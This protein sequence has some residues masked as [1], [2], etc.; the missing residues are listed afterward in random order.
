MALPAIHYMSIYIK[1]LDVL[2]LLNFAIN[3]LVKAIAN[4]N[5]RLVGIVLCNKISRLVI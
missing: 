3:I 5:I 2:I 4:H 1:N